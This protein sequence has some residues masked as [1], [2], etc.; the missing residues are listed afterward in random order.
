MFIQGDN[1]DVDTPLSSYADRRMRN[2]SA[3]QTNPF[4]SSRKRRGFFRYII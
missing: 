2:F 3:A 4:H 1:L